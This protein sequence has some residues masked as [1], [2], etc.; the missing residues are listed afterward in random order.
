MHK[1][2]VKAVYKDVLYITNLSQQIEKLGTAGHYMYHYALEVPAPWTLLS[3]SP[4][5][6]MTT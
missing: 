2:C 5:N 6:P 3:D 4:I 1:K